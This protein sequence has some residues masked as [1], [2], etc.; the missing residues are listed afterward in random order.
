VLRIIFDREESNTF[1]NSLTTEHNSM[2]SILTIIL[3]WSIVVSC[4]NIVGI[5]TPMTYKRIVTKS[6]R[7]AGDETTKS[8]ILLTQKYYYI[9]IIGWPPGLR[10]L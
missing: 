4:Q 6:T 5:I 7:S 1:T 10:I 3:L 2:Y 8:P 9:I